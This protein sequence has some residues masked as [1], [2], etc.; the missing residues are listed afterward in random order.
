MF[1]AHFGLIFGVFSDFVVYLINALSP[2]FLT[3]L[4][5]LVFF[6]NFGDFG[7]FGKIA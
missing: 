6:V 1:L 4:L 2:D 3:V 7:V 5:I